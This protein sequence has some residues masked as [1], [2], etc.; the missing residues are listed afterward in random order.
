MLVFGS[1]DHPEKGASR[2]ARKVCCLFYF[3]RLNI[4]TFWFQRPTFL[5]GQ[6]KIYGRTM[7]TLPFFVKHVWNP[8]LCQFFWPEKQFE[9]RESGKINWQPDPLPSLKLTIRHGIPPFFLVNSIKL[10]DFPA[11]HVRWPEHN[12]IFYR[13][14]LPKQRS[15]CAKKKP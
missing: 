8:R 15:S 11:G 4:L 14:I 12:P 1:L 5:V 7:N 6:S 9:W 10:V 3:F 2:I 13:N